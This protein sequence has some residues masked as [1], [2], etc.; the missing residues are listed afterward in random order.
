MPTVGQVIADRLATAGVRRVYGYP[1]GEV[2]DLIEALR[3]RGLEFILTRHESAA[4]FMAG[5]EGEMTG[6]PGVCLATLG[7]GATN[8]VSGVADA[9][10][11]RQPLLA[12]TGQLPADRYEISP[13]QRIDLG[14]LF[15][16]ITKLSARLTPGNAANLMDKALATAVAERPGP[17]HLELPS[18]V[19][20]KEAAE[21][22]Q[23]GPFGLPQPMEGPAHPLALDHATELLKLFPKAVAL[24]GPGVIRADA[25]GPFW[26]FARAWGLPV[27]VG[28]KAKGVFDEDHPLFTGVIE[29]LGTKVLFDFIHSAEM[30]VTVGFDPVELDKAW[31]YDGP[32]LHIDRAS[33]IDEY[34]HAAAEVVGRLGDTLDTLAWR[35]PKPTP[36]WGEEA[37][38]KV[39]EAL[40]SAI[41]GAPVWS[42]EGVRVRELFEKVRRVMPLE[43][44]VTCDVGAHKFAAG[45]L[46]LTMRPGTFY[47]SNGQSSM[48]YGL[49]TAMA[50]SFV[51]PERPVVAFIGD[52]GLGMYLGELETI[53][54]YG[55]KLGIVVLMDE[56]LSLIRIGQE[57]RGYPEYGVG[58]ANPD[59]THLGKA[60][61]IKTVMAK[62]AAR[63]ASALKGLPADGPVLVG[64]P[65][66]PGS[67]RV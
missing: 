15:R 52:G 39:R 53:A 21:R 43:T 13:H 27:V 8:L 11:D 9:Y 40:R 7:P 17:V 49:P 45:Q 64:V 31:L 60:F 25:A 50:A 3:Q 41:D 37:A 4:A 46:W 56:K 34:W 14:S 54:R 35:A 5:G 59:L 33:N 29:A 62:T 36:E 44:V 55:L 23:G 18:D 38:T 6:V 28:P 51:Y 42:A 1:G 10:L 63:V 65:V 16:P 32:V 26:N 20:T 67:Y 58:F 47:M 2:L 22:P 24:A 30:L 57:R 66:D 12:I 61:G 19:T 48:G